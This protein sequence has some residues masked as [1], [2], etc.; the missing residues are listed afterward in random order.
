MKALIA[1]AALGLASVL[2]HGAAAET[3]GGVYTVQPGDSL[4]VIA[5]KLYKNA[6]MWSI[7]HNRNIDAIGPKPSAI[8]VGM[9]LD[10]ACVNGLPLGLAGGRALQDAT[11]VAAQPI[12]IEAGNAA[13]RH[14]INLLTGDDF[15]PFTG[16]ELHNGGLLTDL[17][18][19]AMTE[20][21]PERGFAIHW[22]DHWA[23]HFDPLL[24]NALLDVGFPWY[25]PNCTELPD[26]YRCKN[27]LFSDPLFETL[28]LMFADASRPVSFAS[29]E[30]LFGK[31]ICRPKG[32]DTSIFNENGRNWLREEKITL[33]VA[34]TP[35]D[36]FDLVLEGGADGV[37]L[38]E[39]TGR[40]KMKEM[41]IADRIQVVPEPISIQSHHVVVHKSHPEAQELLA[42]VND[43][44]RGIREDGSYQKIVEDHL[45]R[46]WAGF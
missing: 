2:G 41:G 20:A 23:A 27:L 42:I 13:V 1:A 28:T 29:D 30:D 16:K 43:G 4:S 6:G 32:Y 12:R 5:D 45:A 17:V 22:V 18:N 46:V 9:K 21:N 36:C 11:P 40:D 25:K 8:R 38:N 14:K 3:C 34:A 26:N 37:V 15:E 19:A 33:V 35:G 31:S 39:F 7:I 24:S 10:L 44:L